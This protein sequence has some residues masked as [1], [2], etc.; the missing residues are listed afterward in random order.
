MN[1]NPFEKGWNDSDAGMDSYEYKCIHC[2]TVVSFKAGEPVTKCTK[3]KRC[4]WTKVSRVGR[5]NHRCAS[6]DTSKSS[7]GPVCES[8]Y[9]GIGHLR[10]MTSFMQ[11]LCSLDAG[12][13]VR[14]CGTPPP[15]PYP[16]PGAR[17]TTPSP[18]TSAPN[19]HIERSSSNS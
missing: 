5:K 3:C 15:P 18:T 11:K 13:L 10:S 7:S 4:V 2:K 16:E 14:T 8:V 12:M 6:V 19:T 1:S 9:F 17:R